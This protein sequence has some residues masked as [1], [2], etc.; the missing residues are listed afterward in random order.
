MAFVQELARPVEY[1]VYVTTEDLGD[2]YFRDPA[3]AKLKKRGSVAE[4]SAQKRPKI[5]KSASEPERIERRRQD[6]LIMVIKAG[7]SLHQGEN[8]IIQFDDAEDRRIVDDVNECL[9]G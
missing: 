6:A 5:D 7:W 2:D 1:Q 9:N 8:Q 4:L 3:D